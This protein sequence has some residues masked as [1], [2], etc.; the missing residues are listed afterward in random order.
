[1]RPVPL[2]PHAAPFASY[3]EALHRVLKDLA[4][5]DLL[6]AREDPDATIIDQSFGDLSSATKISKHGDRVVVTTIT[7]LHGP[8]TAKQVFATLKL[9][10]DAASAT[11]TPKSKKR[12]LNPEVEE[13]DVKA[14]V[15]LMAKPARTEGELSSSLLCR[16]E[17]TDSSSTSGTVTSVLDPVA[18]TGGFPSPSPSSPPSFDSSMLDGWNERKL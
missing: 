6:L 7:N 18:S 8:G 15:E 13:E 9:R 12:E 14:N 1:M 11:G 4:A 16:R 10:R 5:D 2:F 17:E 3:E